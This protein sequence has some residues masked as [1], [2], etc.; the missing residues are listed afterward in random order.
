MV[1][2]RENQEQQRMYLG[3]VR[4]DFIDVR[5]ISGADVLLP[6]HKTLNDTGV[7]P[8]FI[9]PLTEEEHPALAA[10]WDNPSDDIFDTM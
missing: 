6:V 2:I 3:Q 9:Q 4:V 8:H 1:T 5:I 10:I 7:M